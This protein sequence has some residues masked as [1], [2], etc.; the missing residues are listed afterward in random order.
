MKMKYILSLSLV[1][2]LT[3][4]G[5]L[6]A[7]ASSSGSGSANE[8]SSSSTSSWVANSGSSESGSASEAA[9]SNASSGMSASSGSSKSGSASEAASSNASAAMMA[10][11]GSAQSGS[12]SEAASSNASSAM[13]ASSGSS[14]SGSASEAASSNASSAMMASSRIEPALEKSIRTLSAESRKA[15][16]SEKSASSHLKQLSLAHQSVAKGVLDEPIL[17]AEEAQS[18]L[19]TLMQADAQINNAGLSS[20][21][22]L[23]AAHESAK[24]ALNSHIK[25]LSASKAEKSDA[26]D[27][28]QAG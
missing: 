27:S 4:A 13:M 24:E 8:P 11:S 28:S 15:L 17:S 18:H 23:V 25:A 20:G 6:L 5:S 22:A 19:N 7:S 16:E 12:A 14:K 26:Q 3:L 10:S 9:S 21:H 1:G 2:T